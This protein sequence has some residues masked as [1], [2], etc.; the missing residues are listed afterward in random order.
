MCGIYGWLS[1]GG[2]RSVNAGVLARMGAAL[3]H[4]GP[5]DGGTFVDDCVAL[6]SRRLAIVDLA[7]GRQPLADESGAL[8]L[9]CN[10]E[11]YNAP[12]L[13]RELEKRHRFRTRTDVEVLVHLYE[14]HGAA[15]LERVEG[16]FALALWDSCKRELLLARDRSGEKPL[17]FASRSGATWFAS[18][19]NA[20]RLAPEIGTEPDAAALRLYLMLGYFP[21]PWTPWRDIRKL[22]PGTLAIFQA[23]QPEPR[24]ATWWS[25]RD[26]ATR[27]ATRSGKGGPHRTDV[28]RLRAAIEGS[29][30]RQLMGDVPLGVALSGGLDSALIAT[31][32]AQ[33]LP[34]PLHTFT[35]A[36]SD[37]SYDEH[38][39]AVALAERLG[40]VPHVIHADHAELERAFRTL[41]VHLDEPLGD[42]AVLPV[43]L[44]AEEARRHVKVILGGEGA[45]ELFG[46]YPTYPG[47]LAAAA[48]SRWP[49]WL[50]N[51]IAEPLVNAWRSSD[52]RVTLE[53]MLKR[54]VRDASR[55]VLERHAAWFGV[56]PPQEADALAGPLLR[57]RPGRPDA[58]AVFADLLGDDAAWGASEVA[59][60]M[61]LDAMTFLSEGLLTKM[62]RA[63][64]AC[65][66]EN[67]SPYLGRDVVEL[68]AG[69]P[70]SWKV[71]GLETKRILRAAAR[72][73]VP[74]AFLE[75]RKRGLSVPLAGMFRHELKSTLLDAFEPA[76]LDR[77]GLLDGRAVA[78]LVDDHL[79]RRADRSR[80]LWAMLSLVQWYRHHAVVGPRA[81]PSPDTIAAGSVGVPV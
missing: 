68:A 26:H 32:A 1:T 21:A 75:R 61:Y 55:P 23:G 80:S 7:H 4:R 35:V 2:T 18:E 81:T 15:F 58:V 79:H 59:R 20:L 29:V 44:L 53:F 69:M 64:M 76:R 57:A 48:Y 56:L 14:D 47:H 39:H 10:G 38:T 12:A 13:R 22:A 51:G 50:R 33:R 28:T 46:G 65:S 3:N 8:H 24:H 62:D 70:P 41:A 11:I 25:L 72:G 37:P 5:D 77:E 66:L 31:I 52:R 43:F 40:A 67:R 36:F 49:G 34:T 63:S 30:G 71:R 17:Y 78:R 16:M 9:V 6:G 60:V 45:D 54:F 73:V 42:P 27:G 74:E 19:L